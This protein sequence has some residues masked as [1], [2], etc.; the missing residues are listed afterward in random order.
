MNMK[1]IASLL[2]AVSAF[3]VMSFQ[4][5]ASTPVMFYVNLTVKVPVVGN[6]P[7]VFVAG[8][9]NCFDKTQQWNPLPM[10]HIGNG[11]Y[12]AMVNSC[13]GNINYKYMLGNSWVNV[14]RDASGKDIPNRTVLLPYGTYQVNTNDTV[15][16]WANLVNVKVSV[17]S[18]TTK[19]DVVYMGTSTSNWQANAVALKRNA[20]GTWFTPLY[21]KP[22][23]Q[24]QFK[25]TLGTWTTVE[26]KATG[27][28]I[29]NR[30]INMGTTGFSINQS[31]A[32]WSGR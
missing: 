30:V 8:D 19:A 2:L 11:V 12:N 1:K 18:T 27:A 10:V 16:S 9:F 22:N 32:K 24:L 26:K 20:D 15:A 25:Y 4:S 21:V 28:E 7:N 23:S 17:P 5:F 6:M 3:F 14:E 31:V 29:S 13:Y